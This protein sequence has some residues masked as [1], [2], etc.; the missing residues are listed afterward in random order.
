MK[1]TIISVVL[2]NKEHIE[3]CIQSLINQTYDDIESII[4]DGCSTDGTG[5]IID[6]YRSMISK[7]VHEKD[8]GIYDALNKGIRLATGKVIGILH[9]DDYYEHPKVIENVVNVLASES[10]DS[11]YGDL[12]YVSKK[13]YNKVIRHWRSSTYRLGQFR[14]GWMP[15]HC[16]FFVKKWVYEK[17]GLFRTDFRI[18]ADYELMLRFLEK[19]RISTY[20][21]NDIMIRM[22][23][24]GASNRGL[25]NILRK[26]YE[27]YRAW[28]INGLSGGLSAVLL[29]NISKLPQLL[30]YFRKYPVTD[31]HN[32]R[33]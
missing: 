8:N 33:T 7:V 1:V 23:V 28:Q 15:P 14:K 17:Y 30:A 11:C 4:I 24:G 2:N 6:R 29:K 22:R 25:G 5:E 21:I 3:A 12:L 26:S 9:S 20:Y 32:T 16:T 31:S 19:K 27:D 18:A 10:I 13:D